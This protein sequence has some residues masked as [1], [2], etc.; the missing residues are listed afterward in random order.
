MLSEILTDYKIN[1]INTYMISEL[2]TEEKILTDLGLNEIEAKV[3]M[4]VLELGSDT[5][6]KISKKA[7]VK[8][9][10][11]YLTLDNLTDKGYVTK[12]EKKSTTLYSAE[13]PSII[14]NKYNEKINNFKDL[15]PFYEAKF[16]R[17][18]KPKIKFYEGMQELWH[19]YTKILFPAKEIYFFGTDIKKVYEAFPDLIDYWIENYIREY[20]KSKEIISFNKE[21]ID[22]A[23]NEGKLRP[24]RLMPKNLPAFADSVITEDKLLLFHLIIYLV[25]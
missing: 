20:D 25:F 10:T 21:G 19:V 8:R 24:I 3:Y 17:G 1:V 6:L 4:A 12:I 14:L 18:T 16:N 15:L 23:K 9:P 22:Y 2:S 11:A 5:V 13:K 7:G